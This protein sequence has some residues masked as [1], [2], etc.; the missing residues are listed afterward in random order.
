MF[1]QAGFALVENGADARE[2]RRAHDGD[3]T[4]SC[5]RSACSGSGSWAS[6][7]RWAAWARCRPS[8]TTRRSPASSSSRSRATTRPFGHARVLPVARRLHGAR[9]RAVPL[10]DGL[11]GHRG[12]DPHG[13]HG[14]RWRFSSFVSFSFVLSAFMYPIFVNWVWGGGWLAQLGK[15]FR[16]GSR[17]VD[18]AGSS[19]VHMVGG[20]RPSWA[21]RCSAAH[22]Q[23]RPRRQAAAHPAHNV[24]MVVLGTFILAFGWVR[25]NPGSTLLGMDHAHRRSSP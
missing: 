24:P 23:V 11:H 22:R 19:C 18:F 20:V 1:M 16:L 14:E 2:E 13:R 10:P 17:H 3:E 8:P 9:G 21:R 12:D 5:T 6:R 25:L 4:S 15:S 7:S